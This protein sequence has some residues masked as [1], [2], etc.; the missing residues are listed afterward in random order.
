MFFDGHKIEYSVHR[1]ESVDGNLYVVGCCEK[2]SQTVSIS[3]LDP[4]V[5]VTNS[6]TIIICIFM[7]LV[8][9]RISIVSIHLWLMW[10]AIDKECQY[11]D[12]AILLM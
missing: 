1:E 10:K 5:G 8:D 7:R 9:T 4:S 2:Q 12:L 3:S 6:H 11:R